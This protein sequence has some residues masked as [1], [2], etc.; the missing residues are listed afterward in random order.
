MKSRVGIFFYGGYL[1]VQPSVTGA[2]EA[3]VDLGHEPAE[4][5]SS[6]QE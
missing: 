2:T 1:G 4:S 6:T 5:L 3:F